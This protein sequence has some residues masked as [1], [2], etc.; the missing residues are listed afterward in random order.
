MSQAA[1]LMGS[2]HLG[3]DVMHEPLNT[4]SPPSKQTT[5]S[6]EKILPAPCFLLPAHDC[7]GFKDSALTYDEAFKC[8]PTVYI[9]LESQKISLT[10]KLISPPALVFCF[11]A[12]LPPS[13]K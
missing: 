7:Q 1:T 12:L 5:G 11:M 2:V 10:M 3:P 4:D 9:L 13:L 8:D 6:R